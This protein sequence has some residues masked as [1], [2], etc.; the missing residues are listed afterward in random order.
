MPAYGPNIRI[1]DRDRDEA[2][3]AIREHY[4]AKTEAD[5]AALRADLPPVLKS[6]R[7]RAQAPQ[8]VRRRAGWRRIFASVGSLIG[9]FAG[10]TIVWVLTGTGY[11]WPVWILVP[12][13]VVAVGEG[14]SML[15]GEPERSELKRRN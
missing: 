9:V 11:F 2:A 6:V 13:A 1:S 5:L 3:E 7:P 10:A 12:M 15:S 4:A 8:Q 14:M